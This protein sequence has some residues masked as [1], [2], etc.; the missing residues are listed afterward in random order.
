MMETSRR[1]RKIGKGRF[2][3]SLLLILK[4]TLSFDEYVRDEYVRDEYVRAKLALSMT[5]GRKWKSEP[6]ERRMLCQD[7][8]ER[9]DW[10]VAAN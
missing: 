5:K 9:R 8:Q 1:G 7:L 2:L 3:L 4:S 6:G 10:S